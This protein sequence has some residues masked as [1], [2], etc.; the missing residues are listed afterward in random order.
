[1]YKETLIVLLLLY[2]YFLSSQ[3]VQKFPVKSGIINYKFDGRLQGTEIICFDDYGKL[4]HNYKVITNSSNK[5]VKNTTTIYKHDSLFEIY[6]SDR[7]IYAKKAPNNILNHKLITLETLELLGYKEAGSKH[8]A[9]FICKSY[10][11]NTGTIWIWN[12]IV[13]KSEIDVLGKTNTVEAT[14]IITDI[15]IPKSKFN[16]P[17]NYKL[18]N[19]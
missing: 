16:I 5:T 9:N 13:L 19:N 14:K 2:G 4:T 7:T 18:I 15:E 11:S 1:M 6:N 3:E 12:N 17:I 8:V 10:I